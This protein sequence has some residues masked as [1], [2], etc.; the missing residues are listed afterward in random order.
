VNA[1]P[2]LSGV[3]ASASFTVE[4]ARSPRSDHRR[5][6][7]G[8]DPACSPKPDRPRGRSPVQNSASPEYLFAAHASEKPMWFVSSRLAAK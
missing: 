8:D 7:R 1:P 4:S 5:L 2:S 6:N 3:A